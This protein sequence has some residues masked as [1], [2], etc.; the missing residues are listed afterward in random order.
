MAIPNGTRFIGISQE[1]DLTER[2]ST[3]LNSLTEPYTIEDISTSAG[4]DSVY[5][6]LIA[7]GTDENTTLILDYGVNIITTSTTQDYAAKL[8]QPVTG[9]SV[10]VVNTSGFPV[11][12]YPSN[13]GG[14]IND[15]PV[16]TPALVPADGKLY[17][18][19]CI[20]NPQP[21]QW[22]VQLP[23]NVILEL[24]EA[25]INHTQG[26][27]SNYHG[28]YT[29]GQFATDP[30][31]IIGLAG[32]NIALTTPTKWES[33]PVGAIAVRSGYYTNAV[34]SDFPTNNADL[35]VERISFYA[36]AYNQSYSTAGQDYAKVG[37]INQ[38][39]VNMQ[40]VTSGGIAPTTPPEIGQVGTYYGE[41]PIFTTVGTPSQQAGQLAAA[42]LGLSNGTQ[43]SDYYFIYAIN[44]D[45]DAVTKTYKVKIF[46]EYQLTS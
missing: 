23:S 6:N 28:V 8:P 24:G 22:S 15:L 10:R 9:R 42:N 27:A 11:Y 25:S 19:V 13:V 34:D 5:D 37:N 29:F 33:L 38:V 16:D 4:T 20:E 36:S 12:V 35:V 40:Q 7:Q 30:E 45:A 43:H 17:N 3:F 46:L 41:T 14:Q 18:F 1:V 26:V 21:G 39:N 2:K 31:T 32:G 44:I